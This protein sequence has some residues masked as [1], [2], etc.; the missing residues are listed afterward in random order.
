[1]NRIST[2]PRL[3]ERSQDSNKG[4]FGKVLIVAGSEGMAGAAVLAGSAALRGGAGLVRLAVPQTILPIVAMGNPCYT[5]IGLAADDHGRVALGS[6]KTIHALLKDNDVLAIGP[7]LR[8]SRELVLWTLRLL[9]S[10]PIP[11][12]VDADAL[13]HLAQATDR[14]THTAPV[15]ITPHPGEFA[16]LVQRDIPT[17]QANREELAVE[18]ARTHKIIVVLKGHET[19]VTDGETVYINST[20]NPGMATGGSGDVLTGLVAALAGQIESPLDAACLGVHVHGQAGDLAAEKMG[21]VAMTATDLLDF[22]PG[23]IQPVT[24]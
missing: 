13:N 3:P 4:N 11:V 22:I 20:G 24:G 12:V 1:M 17:V 10:S 6:F 15:I 16:R 5:T 21:Q 14:F 23:A 7:G 9:A 19:V 18:F 8:Q 2:P